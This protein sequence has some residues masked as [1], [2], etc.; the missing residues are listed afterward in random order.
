MQKFGFLF[1][2]LCTRDV[3][4]YAQA[5]DGD[6]FHYRDNSGLESDLIVR[7]RDGRL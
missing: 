6:V 1:E 5:C 4:V 7:L 3:R 2:S